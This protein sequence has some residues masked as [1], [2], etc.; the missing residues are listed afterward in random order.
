MT[1][2]NNSANSGALE[3]RDIRHLL[4]VYV[5][6][7]IDPAE[8][9]VVDTHL[10]SCQSCR[11]ELAGLAGLPA[12][13]GRV[14]AADV[15]RLTE[16]SEL[17]EN[18]EP[19]AELLNS[20]V[21]K[22]AGRRRSRLWKSAVGIAAA[23]VLAAGGA[24]AAVQLAQPG[25]QAAHADVARASNPTTGVAAVVD[26]ARTPWGGTTMRVQVSGVQPGTTCQFYVTGSD[27]RGLAGQWTV[28]NSYGDKAWYPAA[29][30]SGPSSVRSFLLTTV[31]GQTLL[32]IP[33]S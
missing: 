24:V 30:A 12:M 9:S 16:P 5:V 29:S 32:K 20:L 3:C 25:A 4:G 1:K 17:P 10:T 15:E 14:P 21:S 33:A 31:S 8:R 28:Q 23:A 6:G 13:L 26:Y 19:S 22:V 7:A 18:V 11:D 2:S 27:G